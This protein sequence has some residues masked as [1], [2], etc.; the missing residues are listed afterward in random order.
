[1]LHTIA[2]KL[3][4]DGRRLAVTAR[5]IAPKTWSWRLYYT[6]NAYIDGELVADATTV[7][8][9]VHHAARTALAAAERQSS[10]CNVYIRL[11]GVDA[12]D[13]DDILVDR[14]DHSL[15]A[16]LVASWRDDHGTPVT[17]LRA[18]RPGDAAAL[19]LAASSQYRSAPYVRVTTDPRDAFDRPDA[20][21]Y[22]P[23]AMQLAHAS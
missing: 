14:F 20:V 2:M 10:G 18:V 3:A 11:D 4:H 17:V 8:P 21:R 6:A 9:A 19:G 12:R 22:V 7:C 5:R 23:A 15:D 16:S 1:M 13:L